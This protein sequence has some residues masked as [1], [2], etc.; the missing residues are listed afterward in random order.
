MPTLRH[1]PTT[2]RP[3]FN[4]F[5][6][7]HYACACVRASSCDCVCVLCYVTIVAPVFSVFAWLCVCLC[8]VFGLCLRWACV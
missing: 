2:H 6:T 3:P 7:P 5:L 1:L 4:L 8:F